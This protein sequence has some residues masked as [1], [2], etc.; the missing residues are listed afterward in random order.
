[1]ALLLLK[2]SQQVCICGQEITFPEG[3]VRAKCQSKYCGAIWTLG[4]EGFWLITSTPHTPSYG[5]MKERRKDRYE[6]IMKH[7]KGIKR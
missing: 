5:K 4:E 6:G 2:Q 1:M 7:R 3:Q